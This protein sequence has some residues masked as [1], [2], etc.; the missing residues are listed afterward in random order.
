M[1]VICLLLEQGPLLVAD[2]NSLISGLELAFSLHLPQ[3]A[4]S[5]APLL[6]SSVMWLCV[7]ATALKEEKRRHLE[8]SL[9]RTLHCL[10]TFR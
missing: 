4:L 9:D 8:A 1:K 2:A 3:Q 5:A 10:E 6:H 7:Q